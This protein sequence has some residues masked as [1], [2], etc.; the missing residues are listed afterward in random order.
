VATMT[1]HPDDTKSVAAWFEQWGPMVADQA[2]ESA[3]TLFSEDVV[4]FGT[5]M[6]AVEGLDA[7]EARQWRT[8]WPTIDGFR[9][10]TESLRVFVSNDRLLATAMVV[11][12]ST[13]FDTRGVSYPRPGRTTAVLARDSLAAPWLGVHTHF[14]Q[15]PAEDQRSFGKP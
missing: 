9:F 1:T 8:I 12:E 11:W 14:S 10:A 15:F 7:L 13:G 4:G 6:D 3:R 5:F 2:F